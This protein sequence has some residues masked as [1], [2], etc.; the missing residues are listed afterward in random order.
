[1]AVSSLAVSVGALAAEA[2]APGAAAKA[3]FDQMVSQ[4]L[5]YSAYA[6]PF[7]IGVT[8]SLIGIKLFKKFVNRA[9]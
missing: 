1:M 8:G 6:W 2:G 9:S 7:A 3:A 4:T 5:E